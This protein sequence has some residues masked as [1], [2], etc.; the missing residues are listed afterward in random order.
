[1]KIKLALFY[2]GR[3]GEHEVSL[4]SAA[5][6]YDHLDRNKYEV[7]PIGVTLEGRWYLQ[8]EFSQ[9]GRVAHGEKLWITI[10]PAKEV[11]VVPGRGLNAGGRFLSLDAA[12]LITHGTFGE[13]GRLQ[14]LLE[15]AGLPYT[16]SHVLGSALGMDKDKVKEVWQQKGI[17]V[18]PWLTLRRED[19]GTPG[20]WQKAEKDVDG[21]FCWPVFVKS[22][23]SGSSVGVAKVSDPSQLRAAVESAFAIDT[24]VLIEPAINA[25]EIEVAV[26]GSHGQEKAYGP[27]EI[28]PSHEF[29]DYE[30]KYKDPNGAI[31]QIPAK[32][33]TVLAMEIK[34]VALQ[35]F[36]VC[37]AR[38]FSR[39]DFFLDKDNGKIY[40]NEINTLPGF[41]SISMFPMMCMEDGDVT[42][43]QV[44]DKIIQ[45]ALVAK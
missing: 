17:S 21:L 16:G 25:R 37:E 34:T 12:F 1:M 23:N 27:G 43:A 9:E 14:G 19:S 26:L 5:S 42:Y 13:D 30:A 11:S 2:G 6:I 24:K 38:G 45:A 39:V 35:A 8:D 10:D 22:S 33:D 15:Y 3:S 18:V 29:Y 32:I 4:R 44:L 7:K 20:F 31:L 40:L 28:V 41:T 36:Q